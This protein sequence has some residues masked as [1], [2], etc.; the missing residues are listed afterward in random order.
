MIVLRADQ[1]GKHTGNMLRTT[2]DPICHAG[3][4]G[5]RRRDV[6]SLIQF[7]GLKCLSKNEEKARHRK[8]VGVVEE[9][10]YALR[11]HFQL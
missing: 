5:G 10:K 1:Q 7:C 6:A 8:E 3:S 9:E 4:E 11:L 2:L